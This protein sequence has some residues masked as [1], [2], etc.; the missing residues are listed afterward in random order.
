MQER[1]SY[2]P[3]VPCWLDIRPSDPQAAKEFYGGVFGWEFVDTAPEGAPVPYY[4]AQLRGLSVAAIGGARPGADGSG[5]NPYTAVDS[6]DR[7]VERVRQAGGTV[8]SEPMDIPGAGRMASFADS[9]GAV[10][11]VWEAR[12]FNGAQ[13][14]NEPG[15][16][17]FSELHTSDPGSAAKFY[18]TVFDWDVVDFS[19]GDSAYR[20]FKLDGYGASLAKNNPEFAERIAADESAAAFAD[21]VATLI[22]ESSGPEASS[23][24]RWSV[25]FAVDDADAIA[26]ETE[27]L[28]GKIIVPPFDVEP[29]RMTVL[30]DAQGAVF[31]A[32]KFQPTA[33]PQAT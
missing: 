16:W 32:S 26:A 11:S 29:V 24:A 20:F 28:G 5:W 3:G 6:A 13:L 8:V 2:L 33:Q 9:E 4:V 21:V 1:K 18:R 10:F 25:T 14:V 31:A 23:A 15:T 22:D 30:A 27:R 12:G 19:V 17:N 7:A